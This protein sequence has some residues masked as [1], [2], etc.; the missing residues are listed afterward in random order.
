[1]SH[2][3]FFFLNRD[4]LCELALMSPKDRKNQALWIDTPEPFPWLKL[5]QDINFRAPNPPPHSK[6]ILCQN[7]CRFGL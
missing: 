4:L 3:F 5:E 6:A 2:F 7:S 1:M